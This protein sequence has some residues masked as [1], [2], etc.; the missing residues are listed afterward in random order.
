MMKAITFDLWNTLLEDKDFT[1]HRI[2]SLLRILG[3]EGFPIPEKDLLSAYESASDRY[4]RMWE[5]DRRHLHVDRRVEHMLKQLGVELTDEVKLS[6]VEEFTEAF[7]VDPP[8][9]KEDVREVLESLGEHYVMGI[10]S[11]TGVTPG[12][13]IREHL[14]KCG[15]LR[16]FSSTVFSDEVGF[17]KPDPRVFEKALRELKVRAGEAVHVGDLLRTD[18]AGAKNV[19]MKAV[20]LSDKGDVGHIDCAPDY[21]INR[22]SELLVVLDKF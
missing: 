21:V 20:W 19:G 16:F 2:N 1:K 4:R 11:D 22:L 8:A 6:I 12:S 7:V 14:R 5:I 18:V 3:F 17:C 15:I 10:I 9:F 13:I